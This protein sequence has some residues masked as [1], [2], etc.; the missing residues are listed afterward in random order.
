MIPAAMRIVL[1]S[2]VV[3]LV[4]GLPASA[5]A[6][7]TVGDNV[8]APP[9]SYGGQLR[10]GKD[11]P[12]GQRWDSGDAGVSAAPQSLASP[13][14]VTVEA[15]KIRNYMGPLA[16]GIHTSVYDNALMSPA[17][18]GILGAAAI[19]TLRYPGGGYSDQYHWSA[20]K[21]TRFKATNPPE[22]GYYAGGND[23][24]NFVK[25]IDKAGTAIITVNYGSNLAGTGGGEP[26]EAAAWVAYCNGAPDN[27][28][29]IGKDSTGYDWKTVGYW[30]TMR[31][32][33]PL[34]SDDGFNFLRI[35]H[36]RPLNIAYWEIGNEVFGNGY[37]DRDTKGGFEEDLHAGYG[38]TEA[39]TDKLR[40]HNAALSPTA[41]G[42]GVVE[43]ARAMKAVDPHVRIG[44]V[45][46]TPPM[47]SSWGPDWNA[48]V[49]KECGTAIDFVIIHWY[50]GDLLPPDWK[51]LDEAS[52]LRK[53]QEDLPPMATAL[54]ELFHKYC[55]AKAAKMQFIVS[56]MGTRPYAR[57]S[58]P[59]TQG[60][61]AGD[62]YISLM[63][64]GAA[65]ID[66]L[67]L[68][69]NYFLD[70]KNQPGP[71]FFGIQMAHL[72]LSVDDALVESHSSSGLLTV[73]ASKRAD[74]SIGVM[75]VNKHPKDTAT[76][77]L[78]V[79]GAKL[80][81][82]GVRFDWG[83]ASPASGYPVTRNALPD[84]GSTMTITVPP[85][86]ITDLV[87]PAAK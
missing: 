22:Y 63:E 59:L 44:A 3:F 83:S 49:L 8:S 42:R 80:G 7:A 48:S 78:K 61:F 12:T 25:Q 86:T 62:G 37:Y 74:G 31:A 26:T 56:E 38:S 82:S 9:Q 16:M 60:L 33:A 27:N 23:F 13:V 51:M 67:E 35:S 43:F 81:A 29:V 4:I 69:A 58:T 5:R 71:A 15:D 65:N 41:Y 70:E 52:L 14:K 45:L 46:N 75:L 11:A 57:I 47:D 50:T 30:A 76:V 73:H 20:Y 19:H 87:L 84:A 36:P 68:H 39:A 24:G 2:L 32:S 34:A 21:A 10:N 66:W 1:L 18:P 40:H 55:G 6:Q 17:V 64:I 77:K 28:T 53:P 79:S 72:L 54:A 85:Y